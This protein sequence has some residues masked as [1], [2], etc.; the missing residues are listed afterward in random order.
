ME[1]SQQQY[2]GPDRRQSQTQ[3]QYQ[4]EERR[5]PQP[6]FEEPTGSP[7]N[8]NPGMSTQERKE[9]QEER[10]RQQ[11]EKYHDTH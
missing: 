11:E 7:D 4:G 6:M 9:E 5:Q 1:Q 3:S 10:T 2:Q 8:G